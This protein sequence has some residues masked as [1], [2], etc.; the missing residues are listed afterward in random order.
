MLIIFKIYAYLNYFMAGLT[1]IDTLI[2]PPEIMSA[3][4]TIIWFA[5]AGYVVMHLIGRIEE[6]HGR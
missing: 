4:L 6:A 1:L 3:Y 5:V 2:E